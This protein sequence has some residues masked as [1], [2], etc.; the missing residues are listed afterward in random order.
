[1]NKHF[2]ARIPGELLTYERGRPVLYSRTWN[3]LS[4]FRPEVGPGG[5]ALPHVSYDALP[6]A[7]ASRAAV[8]SRYSVLL[9]WKAAES[10]GAR[11]S[12][13]HTIL[14][15]PPELSTEE[16]MDEEPEREEEAAA[17]AGAEGGASADA[18]A[19]ARDGSGGE[20]RR[21]DGGGK[22]GAGG[23]A[24]AP[25]ARAAR[26]KRGARVRS[27]YERLHRWLWGLRL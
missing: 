11:K 19:A 1:V 2:S 27:M 18:S 15:E 14:F 5:R 26:R 25:P 7:H 20:P 21:A 10:G 17:Q 23:G 4:H 24:G 6:A 12:F 13:A 9:P 16:V 8:E 3:H 22:G